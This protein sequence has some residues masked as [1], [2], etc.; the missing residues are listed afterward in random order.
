MTNGSTPGTPNPPAAPRR[1]PRPRDAA[2]RLGPSKGLA[3]ELGLPSAGEQGPPWDHGD[4]RPDGRAWWRHELFPIE[5]TPPDV[6]A[7]WYQNDKKTEQRGGA[8]EP[9][10]L[11]ITRW[12][13]E[14]QTWVDLPG[15]Y[16]L[17]GLD[18]D[19]F[20][21]RFGAG[22]YTLTAWTWIPGPEGSETRR[23]TAVRGRGFFIGPEKIDEGDPEHPDPD[24]DNE[25]E[26]DDTPIGG[27]E[28]GDL[29]AR[30]FELES[31][32]LEIESRKLDQQNADRAQRDRW[33]REDRERKERIEREDR[34]RRERTEREERQAKDERDRWREH[35][36]A[37]VEM[38]TR[39]ATPGVAPSN[40]IA[41]AV[42]GA[43]A[44]IAAKRIPELLG[45][46]AV[47]QSGLATLG[48]KAIEALGSAVSDIGG[49]I[50]MAYAQKVGVDVKAIFGGEEGAP[51]QPAPA[52][53]RDVLTGDDE[54]DEEEG[55]ET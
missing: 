18:R 54:E 39:A 37:M 24:D 41:D 16:A 55:A 45:G 23:M 50:A 21:R 9:E 10:I 5:L 47:E 32:R 25:E 44:A 53:V 40:P 29:G 33:A 48:A 36:R 1:R 38:M 46:A 13:D 26:E 34:E 35:Q 27:D 19:R 30:T 3:A 51:S 17:A 14:A 8:G 49:P 11:T 20:L 22:R 12:N 52:P 7:R 43:V 2:S 31:R 4:T 15:R 28:A 6:V 42:M